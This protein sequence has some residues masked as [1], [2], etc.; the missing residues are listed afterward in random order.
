VTLRLGSRALTVPVIDR[1][2]YVAGRDYDLTFATKVA[3]GAGDVSMIW[4]SA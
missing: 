4:A 2:P 1:G 3:L